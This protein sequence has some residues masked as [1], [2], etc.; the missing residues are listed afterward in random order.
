MTIDI[1]VIRP[2]DFLRT[3]PDGKLDMVG[4]LDLLREISREVKR[5]AIERV[6]VDTRAARSN[7]NT[8]DLFILAEQFARD[9]DLARAMVALLAPEQRIDKANFL[10]L[11]ADNRGAHARAFA[12]FENA[13][14]WLIMDPGSKPGPSDTH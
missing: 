13:I 8:A 7:L 6:L 11:V 4:S 9:S 10:T 14:D 12:N 2:R 3:Q 1:R 5:A